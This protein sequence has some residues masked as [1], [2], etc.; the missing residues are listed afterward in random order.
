MTSIA[1]SELQHRLGNHAA[2]PLIDVRTPREYAQAHVPQAQ[3]VP[4]DQLD[5]HGLQALIATGISPSEPV[6]VLCHSDARARKAAD[7]LSKSGFTTPIVIEGGTQAWVDAGYPVTR[8]TT[9]TK[10]ATISLERQV[11][12]AAGALVTTGVVLSLLVH[13]CFIGLSAFVGIGLMVAGITD[14][15]GMALLL[16]KAPWNR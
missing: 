9:G 3:S 10:G 6:Y 16:A 8:D 12:I 2:L 15:C 14:W 4:L 7:L 13:P 1:P 5:Q 11:R